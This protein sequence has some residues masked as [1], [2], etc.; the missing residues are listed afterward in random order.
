M[1]VFWT[2]LACTEAETGSH[3]VKCLGIQVGLVVHIFLL[4]LIVDFLDFFYQCFCYLR[5]SNR[6]SWILLG[7]NWLFLSFHFDNWCFNE[8]RINHSLY[9]PFNIFF[10][11]WDF[12]LDFCIS[13]ACVFQK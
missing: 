13:H 5:S 4:S 12:S 11:S 1:E 2:S 7:L 9:S 8:S 3:V 6:W 10:R